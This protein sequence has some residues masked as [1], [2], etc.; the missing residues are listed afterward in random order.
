M[1]FIKLA[2]LIFVGVAIGEIAWWMW[3]RVDKPLAVAFSIF[4]LLFLMWIA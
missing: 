3:T 1:T 4:A 2:A